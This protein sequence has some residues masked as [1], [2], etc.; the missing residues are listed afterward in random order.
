METNKLDVLAYV[1]DERSKSPEFPDEVVFSDLYHAS[2]HTSL[3][4]INGYPDRVKEEHRKNGSEWSENEWIREESSKSS[5]IRV[6][7]FDNLVAVLNNGKASCD[8]FFYNYYHNNSKLHFI[9]EF[10]N[11]SKQIFLKKLKGNDKDSLHKKVNDSIENICKN[12]LFGGT[13]EAE[14]VVQNMHFFAV[15]GGKNTAATST[16]PYVP[17]KK[18][19]SR[20]AEGKQRRATRTPRPE[21]SE[22]E[23]YDIYGQ[24]GKKLEHL[25]MKPRTEKLFLPIKVNS[26]ISSYFT[27]F[28]AQDFGKLINSGF[29]DDWNWGPYLPDEEC[30]TE[31]T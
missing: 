21:Y 6:I 13:H 9:A 8:A 27:P 3:R 17:S 15:Y 10:K 18:N 12:L 14:A 24:F 22:K 5:D 16:R 11:E 31:N 2:L 4:A 30:S 29:F 26:R 25:G 23:E 1:I 28:S 19:A 20:N 7:D